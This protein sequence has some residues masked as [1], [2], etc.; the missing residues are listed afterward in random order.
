MKKA[1]KKFGK[2]IESVDL[3]DLNTFKV[4]GKAKYLVK[5]DS[6]GDVQD[7][8]EFLKNHNIKYYVIGNGSNLIFSDKD[9]DG[10]IIKLDNLSAI[11]VYSA[12]NSAFA[13]A[14]AM[15]SK[16]SMECLEEGLTG[17]EWACGI[18]GTVGGAVVTN[19]GAYKS[20][21]FD[22]LKN[23][24]VIDPEGNLK[25]MNKDEITHGYRTSLFK[26]NK[27]Y[28]ILVAEF[29]LSSGDIKASKELIDSR[30]K[31][32][33]QDQP[34]EYPSAGSV[35]RNPDPTLIKDIIDKYKLEKTQAGYLIESCGLKGK[36][37]GGAMISDKHANFIINTG[38]AK[39]EDIKNLI[40]IAH[41]EVM[42]KYGIDLIIEQEFVNWE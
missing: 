23:V 36:K 21:T 7:L 35:F 37:V 42:K 29:E 25:K 3:K 30:R 12:I 14:G 5:P 24:T 16:L 15:L 34:L 20:E 27:D 11:E 9:F 2:C 40:D 28:I 13:E 10:V 18:P 26:E 17:F 1:L 19:A 39:A 41:N 38:N 22:Y 4:G 6:A 31:R 8:I 32:R 33:I